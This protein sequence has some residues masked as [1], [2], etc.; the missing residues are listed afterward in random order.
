MG[1]HRLELRVATSNAAALA[2]YRKAGFESEGLIRQSAMLDG[3][4]I[5]ELLMGKLLGAGA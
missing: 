1:C 3:E 4:P 5:D 2:L